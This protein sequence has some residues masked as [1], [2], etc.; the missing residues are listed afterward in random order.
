MKKVM[1]LGLGNDIRCDDGVGFLIVREAAKRLG[2][3][4]NIEV[5]ECPQM[6]LEILDHFI[7]RDVV[8]IVDSV[9]TGKAPVGSIIELEEADLKPLT[10]TS[11]HYLGVPETLEIGRAL[12]E[13]I[14]ATVRI[15]AVEVA[16][17]Y[18]VGTNMT[19]EVEAAIPL[20]VEKVL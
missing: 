20:A 11:I 13:N 9:M 12:G 19:R 6:G 18:T 5:V 10:V 16:D 2:N 8:I 3:P 7:G 15:I 4:A 1:L 14:P 17:P